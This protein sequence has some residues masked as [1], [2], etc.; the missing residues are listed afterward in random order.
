[1]HKVYLV[2]STRYDYNDEY[3]TEEGGNYV[4][5]AYTTRALAEQRRDVLNRDHMRTVLKEDFREWYPG[6]ITCA[7]DDHGNYEDW[8][9]TIKRM[10]KL[11]T[12]EAERGEKPCPTIKAKT[13]YLDGRVGFS[14]DVVAAISDEDL[15]WLGDV[16]GMRPVHVEVIELET[17]AVS[18]P[19]ASG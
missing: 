2:C 14:S 16:L 7:L 9:Q 11:L 19:I 8:G 1:M 6:E 17:D 15:D 13:V 5:N 18:T 3:Y 10:Y 4:T 12:T